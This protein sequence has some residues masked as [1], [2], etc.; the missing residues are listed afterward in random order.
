MITCSNEP[1]R[2]ESCFSCLEYV[3]IY[4]QGTFQSPKVQ[5]EDKTEPRDFY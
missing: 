1:L 2:G 5:G 3:S 4:L